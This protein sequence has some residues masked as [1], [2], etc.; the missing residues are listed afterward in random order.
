[1]RSEDCRLGAGA[2]IVWRAHHVGVVCHTTVPAYTV[3][4]V[5]VHRGLPVPEAL[6]KGCW[7]PRP[8]ALLCSA[9]HTLLGASRLLWPRCLMLMVGLLRR[10]LSMPG[11]GPAS[12]QAAV[13]L[14]ATA[15]LVSFITFRWVFLEGVTGS[16]QQA[17]HPPRA[18]PV[19]QVLLRASHRAPGGGRH[20]A[21][22]AFSVALLPHPVTGSYPRA[23]TG[24][25]PHPT[26]G[27]VTGPAGF[28]V[29]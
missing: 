27:D 23:G 13:G 17:S 24:A 21:T 3:Q 4:P 22:W 7:V 1:M 10:D 19:H 6:L 2:G 11:C 5:P 9:C 8:T 12:L 14:L 18:G 29:L 15:W 25:G 16:R 20:A 26:E 28:S